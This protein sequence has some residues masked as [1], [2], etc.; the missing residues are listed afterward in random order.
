M[1]HNMSEDVNISTTN[2]KVLPILRIA[3]VQYRVHKSP[4]SEAHEYNP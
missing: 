1:D 3:K 4:H 2:E